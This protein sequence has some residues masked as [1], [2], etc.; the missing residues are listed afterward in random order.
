MRL[1]FRLACPRARPLT[2]DT[3]EFRAAR[4]WPPAEVA[5]AD[6]AVFD[7]HFTRFLAKTAR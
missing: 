3:G 4:W 5:A 2:L 1:W 6:P 7:P